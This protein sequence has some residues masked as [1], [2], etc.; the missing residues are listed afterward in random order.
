MAETVPLIETQGEPDGGSGGADPAPELD[1]EARAGGPSIRWTSADGT[2][3]V[4][5]GQ[6]LMLWL[7]MIQTTLLIVV[8]YRQVSD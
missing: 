3:T 7:T 8:L 5:D 4:I 1:V 2:T 6:D